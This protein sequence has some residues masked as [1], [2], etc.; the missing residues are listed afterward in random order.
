MFEHVS[1][2][3]QDLA[4]G[5]KDALMGK[6]NNNQV[7]DLEVEWLSVLD[8]MIKNLPIQLINSL[9]KEFDSERIKQLFTLIEHLKILIVNSDPDRSNSHLT[10]PESNEEW[11]SSKAWILIG[12]DILGRGL[13]IPQLTVTYFLRQAKIPNFDTVSQQMRFCGYRSRYTNFVFIHCQEDTYNLFKFMHEIDS[14]VWRRAAI[15]DETRLDILSTLPAVLYASRGGIKLE[16][17]RKS[18]TDPDLID[19][20]ITE[21]VFSLRSIFDPNDFRLNLSTLKNFIQETK[22]KQIDRGSWIEFIDPLDSNFQRIIATWNTPDARES[23]LLIGAAELFN[24]EMGELGL[25]NI[26]KRIFV[27]K[28]LLTSIDSISDLNSFTD[29]I[30]MTRRSNPKQSIHNLANWNKIFL[31][32]MTIGMKM[33]KWPSLAVS[34][35]GDGQRKLRDELGLIASILIIEP[36]LALEKT[37]D[38]SSALAMGCA[39]TL[40]SPLEYDLRLIGHRI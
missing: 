25:V 10:L 5:L 17:V 9:S 14:T 36:T 4:D 39:F 28:N 6:L 26:P 38:R 11:N 15:W 13:T 19:Q 22:I 12:G 40:M 2:L 18:V 3:R 1:L 37:R 31:N 35:I 27:R 32:G 8:S 34:H 21:N 33:P 7:K 20:K 24:E 23:A 16:P 29:S 30:D